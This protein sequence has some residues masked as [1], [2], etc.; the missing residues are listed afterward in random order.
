MPFGLLLGFFGH[1]LAH[2]YE[3]QKRQ[4]ESRGNYLLFIFRL[5]AAAVIRYQLFMYQ[6][7]YYLF[8]S[9]LIIKRNIYSLCVIDSDEPT[10]N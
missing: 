5:L 3:K 9:F 6:I 2:G 4:Q 8:L 7:T 10:K 1:F